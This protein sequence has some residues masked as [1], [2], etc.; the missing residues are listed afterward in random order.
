MNGPRRVQGV[1][2]GA[3]GIERANRFLSN[4]G[5]LT[6]ADHRDPAPTT[7]DRVRDGGE[8]IVETAGD[9]I[10]RRGLRAET[11]RAY[12]NRSNGGCVGS[13]TWHV[14]VPVLG[15]TRKE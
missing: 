3:G 8:T 4:V 11:R 12:A 1:S 9:D 13:V 6:D 2:A 10:E 14:L 7:K 5:G 15:I